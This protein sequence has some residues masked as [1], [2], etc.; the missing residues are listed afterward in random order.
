MKEG[1]H[2][3]GRGLIV[4]LGWLVCHIRLTN[5]HF[6]FSSLSFI[7]HFITSLS[8]TLSDLS[9]SFLIPF[10]TLFLLI[11]LMLDIF[12]IYHNVLMGNPQSM[13]YEVLLHIASHT[14]R[15]WGFCCWCWDWALKSMTWCNRLRFTYKFIY[16][17]FLVSLKYLFC[18]NW[19]FEYTCP[20]SLT[21]Y[22]TLSNWSTCLKL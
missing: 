1:G 14:C 15:V 16:L 4:I 20:T 22:M 7:L 10:D 21:L 5:T 8:S 17:C 12:F 19:L 11:L 3:L 6:P 18:I 9:F 13:T 2:K